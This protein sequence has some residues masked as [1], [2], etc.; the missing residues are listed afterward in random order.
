MKSTL[1][2][3]QTETTLPTWNDDPDLSKWTE[4]HSQI[5]QQLAQTESQHHALSE[6]IQQAEK[7]LVSTRSEV[8]LGQ[9]NESEVTKC[10]KKLQTLRE[11]HDSL[12]MEIQALRMA[13]SKAQSSIQDAKKEAKVR[14]AESLLPT[15]REKLS[16]VLTALQLAVD[17]NE[18]LMAF[19]KHIASQNLYKE[20]FF[21]SLQKTISATIG[22]S[23][24]WFPDG[25]S[26]WA[27]FMEPV[28]HD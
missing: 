19:E 6:Q 14:A 18:A 25:V 5:S 13:Q 3:T 12:S 7:D 4:K 8:I 20:E 27:K 28:M 11:E 22:N 1:E 2:V 23:R 9:S 10:E 26:A 15:Y 21:D 24:D 17:A 16:S